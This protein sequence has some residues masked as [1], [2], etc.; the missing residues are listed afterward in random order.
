MGVYRIGPFL[1]GLVETVGLNRATVGC[2]F[3][4]H[5]LILRGID[6]T[7]VSKCVTPVTCVES[8]YLLFLGGMRMSALCIQQ[9]TECP[10]E[11]VQCTCCP[12]S[13]CVYGSRSVVSDSLLS[14]MAAHQIPPF[15]G[16]SR[17]EYWSGLPCPSPGD[18]PDPGIE[19]RPP[20]MQADSLWPE[21]PGKLTCLSGLL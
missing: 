6:V 7:Q 12:L 3:S 15:M 17:Q 4:P 11:G 16:F 5:C 19:P 18:L 8:K 21:S 10:Q 20:A 1:F 13:K 2:V 9:R 14:W